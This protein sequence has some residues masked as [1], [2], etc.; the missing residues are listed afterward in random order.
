MENSP[1]R[2]MATTEEKTTVTGPKPGAVA[3]TIYTTDEFSAWIHVKRA[4]LEKARSMGIGNYPP[5]LKLGG[6]RVGYRHIDILNW[7]SANR[8]I[9]DGSRL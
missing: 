1:L 8:I 4:T 2:K 5:H 7:M 6:R 3:D 9:L